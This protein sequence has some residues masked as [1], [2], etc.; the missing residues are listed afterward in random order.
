[1][2]NARGERVDRPF[3][4]KLL[5]EATQRAEAYSVTLHQEDGDWYGTITEM[6]NVMN[7]GRT[8]T[9]AVKAAREML[10][11]V[12]AFMAEEGQTPPPPMSDVR[13][14]QVNVRV[15]GYE[16]QRLERSAKAAGFRGVSDFVRHAALEKAR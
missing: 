5:A 14:R 3:E 6:D 12:L 15:S 8:P 7:H 10:V 16:K 1:M 4:K 13:D 2:L 11:T 9:A